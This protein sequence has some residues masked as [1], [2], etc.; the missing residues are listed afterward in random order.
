MAFI[1]DALEA[2]DHDDFA[3]FEALKE[4]SGS[5]DAVLAQL[6]GGI[7]SGMGYLGARDLSALRSKARYIRVSP[8]GLRE[9]S[10]HDVV[11]IKA[12]SQR[13]E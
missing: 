4:V 1:G 11:E 6:V 12:G 3:F 9:A 8:A 2:C 7:Q 5:V 13:T 10:P